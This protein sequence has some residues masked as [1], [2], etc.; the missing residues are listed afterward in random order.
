MKVSSVTERLQK[1][2]DL[3]L[4][5]A[6]QDQ[7]E[8]P[9]MPSRQ[10]VNLKP[11]KLKTRVESPPLDIVDR[12]MVNT[13][14]STGPAYDLARAIVEECF[15]PFGD[16]ELNEP[17]DAICE[18]IGARKGNSGLVVDEKNLLSLSNDLDP[19]QMEYLHIAIANCSFR[20]QISRLNLQYPKAPN[21]DIILSLI[22]PKDTRDSNKL[23]DFKFGLINLRSQLI[24]LANRVV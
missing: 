6:V 1:L 3:G 16:K 18:E 24:E 17:C 2:Q 10:G 4:K 14:L 8:L 7:T 15:D 12:A 20:D 9:K 21:L 5:L 19:Q 13:V 23:L 11:D 22:D